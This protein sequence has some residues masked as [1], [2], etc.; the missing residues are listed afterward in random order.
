MNELASD[1]DYLAR[2]RALAP[3][4]AALADRIEAERRLP[5]E[6]LDALFGAG[7]YRLLLP[8]AFGGGE[9]APARFVE[10]IEAVAMAD[11]S[12][13]W[14][15]GQAAGCAMVAAFVEPEVAATM[16]GR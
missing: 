8:R 9:I 1:T 12:T 3:R 2:A 14:C 6:L 13:A 7:L 15:L 4:L 16:F 10:V 11:A 5:D